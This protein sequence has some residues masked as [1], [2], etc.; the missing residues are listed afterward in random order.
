MVGKSKKSWEK[1]RKKPEFGPGVWNL[2]RKFCPD[3]RDLRTCKLNPGGS[4]EG[5]ELELTQT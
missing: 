3:G 4:P 5:N 1:G 2:L